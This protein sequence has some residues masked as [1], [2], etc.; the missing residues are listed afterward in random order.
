MIKVI[1]GVEN[2]GEELKCECCGSVIHFEDEDLFDVEYYIHDAKRK[3]QAIHCPKCQ[4]LI[5]RWED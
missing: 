3:N 1:D 2:I 5:F 4:C